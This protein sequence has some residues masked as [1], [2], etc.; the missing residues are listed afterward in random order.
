M[1]QRKV[2][3][4]VVEERGPREMDDDGKDW[5]QEE[6]KSEKVESTEHPYCSGRGPGYGYCTH[7]IDSLHM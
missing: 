6:S 7:T 5:W 4:W 3:R 2:A 1:A